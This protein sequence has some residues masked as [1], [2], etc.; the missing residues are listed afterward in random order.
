M[1]L[2]IYLIFFPFLIL[3]IA[4]N[5][6]K[7]QFFWI[8]NRILTFL[9][10]LTFFL[11]G[12]FVLFTSLFIS[13]LF[14][15][16]SFLILLLLHK[17]FREMIIKILHL[18]IESKN[19]RHYFAIL[20]FFC[21][22]FV[23]V[24]SFL[25]MSE[26]GQGLFKTEINTQ[27]NILDVVINELFYLAIAIFGYGYLTRRNLKETLNGLGVQKP[28]FSNILFGFSAGIGLI[29]VV[30]VFSLIFQHFGLEEENID[31]LKNLIS[32]QNAFI[33]GLSAGICEEILFRGAL[34]PK[35]GIILTALLF[36]FLHVQYP[37]LWM[38]FLIF[39]IGIILGYV[40]KFTNTTTAIIV[41]STYNTIQMLMLCFFG[42]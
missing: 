37:A 29:G 19:P 6:L 35:F 21:I 34:Q 4:L 23:A 14:I 41:H 13:V 5:K 7:A 15:L 24:I 33:I 1:D 40:R 18:N 30:I 36:T 2:F 38:L 32:I 9:C 27:L 20:L 17:K 10:F 28:T 3:I 39:T 42:L 31:W 25:W 8:F 22:L 11:S 26:T 12:I 16:A